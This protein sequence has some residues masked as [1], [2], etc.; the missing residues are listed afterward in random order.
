MPGKNYSKKVVGKPKGKVKKKTPSLTK[1]IL[2][3]AVKNMQRRSGGPRGM[4]N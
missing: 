3:P 2:G 4:I 1:T